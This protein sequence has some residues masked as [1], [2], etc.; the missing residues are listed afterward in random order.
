MENCKLFS[1]L[2]VIAICGCQD[3]D[4]LLKDGGVLRDSSGLLPSGDTLIPGPGTANV[5]DRTK[6][7]TALSSAE[8]GLLCDQ[9]AAD[10]GGY[11]RTVTCGASVQ[12]TDTN[13][14][15]CVAGFPQVV[16][17]CTTLKVGDVLGCVEATGSDLC[18]YTLVTECKAI[19]SCL[20]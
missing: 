10:Q 14:A 12:T 4:A 19:V 2:I 11:G 17:L 20:G 6:A 15:S 3:Q 18:K 8:V 13:R 1:V 5:L 9:M 7:L 16:Q